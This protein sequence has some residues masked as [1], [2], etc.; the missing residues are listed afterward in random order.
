[1]LGVNNRNLGSFHIDAG[2]SFR[3][4]ERIKSETGS[5]SG[6][7]LFVSES[8]IRDPELVRELR[9]AGFSGFLMGETFMTTNDPGQSLTRFIQQL[10]GEV[11]PKG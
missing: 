9:R 4:M 11:P 2:V 8:G 6:A 10:T 5:R 7:P 1:M 3:L